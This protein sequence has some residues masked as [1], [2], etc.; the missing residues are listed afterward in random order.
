[1]TEVKRFDRKAKK[2]VMIPAPQSVVEYNKYM[3]GVDLMDSL[4]GYYRIHFRSKKWYTKIFFHILDMVIVNAWRLY[5]IVFDSKDLALYTFKVM[6]AEQLMKSNQLIR[7]RGR[8]GVDSPGTPSGTPK[9]KIRRRNIFPS[10]S[11]ATDQLSHFAK[12]KENRLTCTNCSEKTKIYCEKCQVHLC[13]N[14]K[15]NCFYD[16]HN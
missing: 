11:V 6:V 7:K 13:L 10:F 12:V 3:G 1:M 15:R 5:Q 16:F 9:R 8:P 4:L 14:E 2:R